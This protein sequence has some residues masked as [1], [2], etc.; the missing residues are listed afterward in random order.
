MGAAAAA[1]AWRRGRGWGC[2]WRTRGGAGRCGGGVGG[3][4]RAAQAL[5]RVATNLAQIEAARALR[6]EPRPAGLGLR[7]CSSTT[8]SRSVRRCLGHRGA[9]PRRRGGGM[10]AKVTRGDDVGRAAGLPVRPGQA[11]RAH[12]PARGGAL[13]GLPGEVVA[14]GAD[15]AAGPGAADADLKHDLRAAGLLGGAG[16]GVALLGGDPGRRRAATDA[17]WREVAEDRRR[18]GR[19]GGRRGRRGALGCGAPRA[20]RRRATTTSTS[21]RRWPGG[22]GIGDAT[23]RTFLRGD[24]AAV[25]AV[26]NRFEPAGG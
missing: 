4:V 13:D 7:G 19:A 15:G 5:R 18:G 14:V 1:R 16:H 23:D 21:P 24:Y 12:R 8:R 20:E 2:C 9:P 26:C 3:G 6:G 17:Q 22:P 11:Q 25:R 10:I